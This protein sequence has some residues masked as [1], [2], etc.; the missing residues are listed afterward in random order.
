MDIASLS[1]P[2]RISDLPIDKIAGNPNLSEEEK[3]AAVGRHFEAILLRQFLKDA[4]KP[5]FNSKGAM[6]GAT[7]A[8]YQDMIVDSM[9]NEISKTGKFGFAASFQTQ[10]TPPSLRKAGQSETSQPT[11]PNES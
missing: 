11:L 3:V 6:S 1:R 4:Q 9:A 5:L 8:I 2:S 10:M 7:Q